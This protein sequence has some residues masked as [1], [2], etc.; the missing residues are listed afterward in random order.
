MQPHELANIFPMIEGQAFEELKQD[1]K[2][3]G[4]Q[5]VIITYEG[6]ILDGRNRYKACMEL[7]IE[8][9]Y[10]EYKGNKPLEYVISLN[11]K[12]RHLNES[13]RAVVASK[14]AN[15]PL[16]GSIY[17]SANLPTEGIK[18]EQAARMLN[19]SERTIRTIKQIEREAPQRIKDIE[20]GNTTAHEVIS[21][22]KQE[23][24]KEY[25]AEQ[26]EAIKTG[27][28]TLPSGVY[29]VIVIDPPW[30]YGQVDEYSPDYYMTRVASPYP[31]M[32]IA[33]I[34][35]I[36]IPAAD[37]CVVWLW[38]THKYIFDCR[39][40][41]EAWGFRPVSVL[42]WVKDRMGIGKWLRSQSEYCVMAVKGHPLI[43]LTNETT[44][45]NAKNTGHSVK[46]EEFYAMVDKLCIGRKLDYFARKNRDGWDTFGAQVIP[47]SEK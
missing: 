4:L 41:L 39:D 31:E 30:Q 14:L 8:P 25:I 3:N 26:R 10:E 9:R 29:E 21:E 12:R 37:N 47:G 36:S 13:Q 38:T 46:P 24:R 17:R 20:L 28:A 32:D 40:I 35:N 43:N 2:E 23:K 18:Q 22:L 45:L 7:G 1:I 6:K 16:G 11:L 27:K 15:M 5:Q 42:T 33:E 19:V 34:R 44:V